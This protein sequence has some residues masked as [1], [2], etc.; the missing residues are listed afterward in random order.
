MSNSNETNK[1]L[2]LFELSVGGH[3]PE[4]ISHLIDYWCEHK[5]AGQLDIVVS[6]RFFNQHSD[7]A[8]LV[9]K[10]NSKHIKFLAITPEESAKL[11]PFTTGINRNIRAWQ[12]FQLVLKYAIELK[13]HHV[14]LPYFD[15]RQIPIILGQC[16]PCAYSG[17]YFRPSFH[18][19]HFANYHPSWRDKLQHWREK[20]TLSKVLKDPQLKTIFCLDPFAIDYINKI[21][22]EEKA[23]YLPDPVKVHS[24][25]SSNLEQLKYSLEIKHSRQVHL[26]FGGLGRRKGLDKLLEAIALLPTDLCKKLCI[27]IVGSMADNYYQEIQA[28]I[29]RITSTLPIQIILKNTYIPETEIQNYF[30]LADII[31]APYQRH[32]GM[33]GILNRAAVAQKPVLSSD[34]G[35][36]GEI[37]RRYKLGLAVDSIQVMAIVEG[38]TKFLTEPPDKYCDFSLMKKYA[39]QNTPQ[40]FASTIFQHIL[41]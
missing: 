10:H 11:K 38:L 20:I 24:N 23:I 8:K 18:Y 32:I 5:I 2:M 22:R 21:N 36:M 4:Y 13:P 3:Y 12:E 30:E 41:N 26:L 19:E 35:L 40:K 37:T 28:V 31:L 1:K 9:K 25:S 29:S 27:L 39:E 34:Y 6:P 16:L 7:V 15:A 14:F 17:I 33:S